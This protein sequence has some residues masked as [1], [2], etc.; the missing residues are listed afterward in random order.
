MGIGCYVVIGNYDRQIQYFA[1]VRR[2]LFKWLNRRSQR[3]SYNWEGFDQLLEH[4]KL[5]RPRIRSLESSVR[6]NLS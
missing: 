5:E 3:R 1:Q 4:Y 6:E 2:I